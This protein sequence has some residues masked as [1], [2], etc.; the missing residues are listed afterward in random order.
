MAFFSLHLSNDNAAHSIEDP[1]SASLHLSNICLENPE[2]D[3]V[4]QV[5]LLKKEGKK[6]ASRTVIANLKGNSR[7]MATVNIYVDPVT[8]SF[9]CKGPHKVHL[10]GY[11]EPT[12]D[13]D[14]IDSDDEDSAELVAD[15]EE[16]SS[17]DLMKQLKNLDKKKQAEKSKDSEKKETLKKEEKPKAA[18][19]VVEEESDSEEEEGE[20][21]SM[22]EIEEKDL[23]KMVEALKKAKKETGTEEPK[24]KKEEVKKTEV[25]K[26]KVV[27]EGKVEEEVESDLGDDDIDATMSGLEEEEEDFEEMMAMYAEAKRRKLEMPEGME[28]MCKEL[29]NVSNDKDPKVQALLKGKK[30]KA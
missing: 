14:E 23:Q 7:E 3:G 17:A 28:E 26:P 12:D 27:T 22:E 6:E 29:M 16:A 19:A 25:T 9:A 1:L 4:T 10:S 18:A 21:E 5:F 24:A 13:A 11:Y 20:E 15:A 2:K 30:G 8:D